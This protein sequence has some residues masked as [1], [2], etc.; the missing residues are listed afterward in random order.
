MFHPTKKIISKLFDKFNIN[1]SYYLFNNS[2]LVTYN[3]FSSFYKKNIAKKEFL[4]EQIR[5][6]YGKIGVANEDEI[7]SIN[8]NLLTQLQEIH[9][10]KQSH[11]KFEIDDA[12]KQNIKNIINKDLKQF[13]TNLENY[14]NVRI[15][16]GQSR[17]QRNFP[18]NKNIE[19]Y[20]NNYHCD[21]Y[22]YN[23]FKIFI[24]LHDVSSQHGPLHL[25]KK[26]KAR[27][28][29]KKSNYKSR[30]SYNDEN[31]NT[32]HIYINSGKKND[33]FF[34]NTTEVL[35]KAGIPSEGNYR[36]MLFLVFFA[37]PKKITNQNF[38]YLE[39]CGHDIYDDDLLTRKF[40]KPEGLRGIY[41]LYNE[42]RNS[43]IQ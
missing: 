38:F 18:I 16:L 11:F 3:L 36:D 8:K 42:F 34:C 15:C 41:K 32:S 17:I 5:N 37:I 2:N 1:S 13:L 9:E 30:N 43:K 7:N 14:Y 27:E 24:N 39:D 28:F 21:K 12:I 6:S 33:I 23:L 35:H 31:I 19:A 22:T 29:I 26:E 10:N 20:S 4:N 40:A 25:V